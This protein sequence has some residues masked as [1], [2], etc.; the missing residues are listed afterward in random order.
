MLE[1]VP[2]DEFAAVVLEPVDDAEISGSNSGSNTAVTDQTYSGGSAS[3]SDGYNTDGI[4]E[5]EEQLGA[6]DLGDSSLSKAE[7]FELALGLSAS[8]DS[9]LNKHPADYQLELD[10]VA[11]E[12]DQMQIS[13]SGISLRAREI[14]EVDQ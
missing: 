12:M 3:V 1:D 5:L 9:E 14:P 7:D 6:V 4:C 11:N 2:A 8:I 13:Q 10:V